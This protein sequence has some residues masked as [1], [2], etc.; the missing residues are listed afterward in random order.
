MNIGA[1][2]TIIRNLRYVRNVRRTLARQDRTGRAFSRRAALAGAVIELPCRANIGG[3]VKIGARVVIQHDLALGVT[4]T[5]RLEIGNDTRIGANGTIGC[6]GR[7]RIGE[8]VLIAARC[9]IADFGHAFAENAPVIGQGPTE[10]SSVDIGDG[11]W[12]GINVVVLP[13]VSLGRNCVVAANSVVN[14]S[15]GDGAII[16]GAPAKLIRY[17]GEPDRDA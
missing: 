10:G 6:A 7:M 5:G 8:K 14:R 15:F 17:R 13:G 1:L 16:A 12:L 3:E 4:P 9:F 2:R 11:C